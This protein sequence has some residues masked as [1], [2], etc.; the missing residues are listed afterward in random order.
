M[1]CQQ[2]ADAQLCC[3]VRTWGCIMKELIIRDA[4]QWNRSFG[5]MYYVLPMMKAQGSFPLEPTIN[6]NLLYKISLQC[7]WTLLSTLS[8][9]V[10]K[11]TNQ[12][13]HSHSSSWQRSWYVSVCS[14]LQHVGLPLWNVP[15]T[16]LWP[17]IMQHGRRGGAARMMHVVTRIPCHFLHISV[18]YGTTDHKQIHADP[19]RFN[20][21]EVGLND[22]CDQTMEWG[23]VGFGG[24]HA[25][26]QIQTVKSTKL[27]TTQRLHHD[28]NQGTF[29][30]RTSLIAAILGTCRFLSV[31][32]RVSA[33]YK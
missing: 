28:H 2:I 16:C 22:W 23:R 33:T 31:Y 25:V 4:L 27:Q 13:C 18:L 1:M 7:K 30:K 6:C 5:C 19:I 9:R 26:I 21:D 32:P 12:W 8:T 24:R 14:H 20:E 15:A 29:K 3:K 10:S 11:V 17:C